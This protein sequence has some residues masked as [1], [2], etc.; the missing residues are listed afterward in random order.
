MQTRLDLR[1]GILAGLTGL[2]FLREGG[3]A[4][5]ELFV[6]LHIS[7]SEVY[8]V[9]TREFILAMKIQQVALKA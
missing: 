7:S 2:S 6:S 9:I 8:S 5:F 4:L 1:N 3:E